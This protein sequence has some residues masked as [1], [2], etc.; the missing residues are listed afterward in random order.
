MIHK[1]YFDSTIE[2]DLATIRENYLKLKSAAK[3]SICAAT[4]KANAYGLGLKDIALTLSKAG[5]TN[6]FVAALGEAVF[7]R[8]HLKDANIYVFHGIKKEEAASF[9]Q[10]DITPILNDIEQIEI[11]NEFAKLS[12]RKL[13]AILHFDTGINRLGMDPEDAKTINLNKKILQHL[14]LQFI[15]SHLACS[16]EID[17]VRNQQ[18]LDKFLEICK[19]FPKVKRSISNSG[20]IFL[21]NEYHFD[22]VRPGAAIFGVNPTPY[23]NNPMKNSLYLYTKIIQIKTV[24]RDG[25]IGYGN[26]CPVK[27]GMRIA[28]IPIGY[29]D[30]YA[31][32]L[33]NKGYCFF[34]NTRLIAMGK[35]SM[36]MTVIDVSNIEDGQIKKGDLVEIIGDNINIEELAKMAG[37]ISYE[38]LTS[39]GE[40][41][42]L[43]Y[44]NK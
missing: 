11:W 41:F 44:L 23:T 30:G 3:N 17:N 5:C 32:S 27:K 20:G 14:D 24:K 7:L 9:F 16:N 8:K 1:K 12:K 22:M 26:M 15:M 40:R 10:Y 4:V 25:M 35:I 13:P 21:G 31:R 38:I 28:T 36:D 29:A 34:N 43:K 37:T 2:I 6:F 42:R 33:T 39:L 18:Q 19:Y